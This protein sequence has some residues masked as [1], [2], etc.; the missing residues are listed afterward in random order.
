[1]VSGVTEMYSN[2][3]YLIFGKIAPG[4]EDRGTNFCFKDIR[5]YDCAL[6]V[7]ELSS[8]EVAEYVPGT[9]D[10]PGDPDYPDN[11]GDSD[12]PTETD[13]P[14]A[15][16]A[17]DEPSVT[18]QPGGEEQPG[19]GTAPASSEQNGGCASSVTPSAMLLPAMGGI[20]L[21]AVVWNRYRRSGGK[22]RE[23]VLPGKP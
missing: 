10:N 17:S 14:A 6:T 23:T 13:P 1:M 2:A 22:G 16:D 15:P 9:P 8:I 18:A 20:A 3:T 5:V 11:P 21:S 19:G 12:N 4:M 7:D